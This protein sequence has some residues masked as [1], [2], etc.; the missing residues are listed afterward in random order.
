MWTVLKIHDSNGR[1]ILENIGG[2]GGPVEDRARWAYDGK[3]LF[4]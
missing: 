1:L 4:L 3:P 2:G